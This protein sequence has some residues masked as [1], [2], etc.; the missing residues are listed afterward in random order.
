MAKVSAFAIVQH[1]DGRILLCHRRD[2]DLWNL[3]GGGVEPG[4]SP[5]EA[6]KREVTEEVGLVVN[7]ERLLGI[8]HK[9]EHDELSFSFLCDAIGGFLTLTPEAD[10]IEWFDPLILPANT[11]ERQIERVSD[12]I[13]FGSKVVLADQSEAFM[14]RTISD[15]GTTIVI[16]PGR[17]IDA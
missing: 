16:G 8:Y 12:F 3:P 14:L 1:A 13:R 15:M 5:W 7:V 4:E 17:S 2:R 9:P 10:K 6:V 11:S